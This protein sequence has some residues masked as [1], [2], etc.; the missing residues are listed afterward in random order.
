MKRFVLLVALLLSVL[1]ITQMENYIGQ[2]EAARQPREKDQVDYYLQAFTSKQFDASGRMT[3][4]LDG[5]HL[6]HW[7]EQKRSYIIKPVIYNGIDPQARSRTE[8]EEA[9]LNQDQNQARLE[10]QV[11]S[12]QPAS[13]SRSEMDLSTDYLDYDLQTH[14]ATTKADVLITTPSGSMHSTGMTGKLDE[15]LLE[16]KKNVHSSYEIKK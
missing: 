15:D 4:Q 11:H 12:H 2:Q 14:I 8:A 3:A 6:T 5:E 9:W 1:L 13:G 7:K 16:F 10:K